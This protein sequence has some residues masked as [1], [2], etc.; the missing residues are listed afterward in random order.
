MIEST[1]IKMPL[2]VDDPLPGRI[3]YSSYVIRNMV[4]F[5][6]CL[7]FIPNIV[8]Y[9][10]GNTQLE[11]YL[12]SSL[13]LIGTLVAFYFLARFLIREFLVGSIIRLGNTLK[14]KHSRYS[15]KETITYDL[16][17][18]SSILFES[19]GVNSQYVIYIVEQSGE[20]HAII[21]KFTMVSV[22]K[23]IMEFI[24]K[25]SEVTELQVKK[26]GCS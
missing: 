16:G 7:V 14:H 24:S 1:E 23:E 21:E 20:R 13:T 3:L 22:E 12:P 25:L 19:L 6:L 18:M 2:I 11:S 4:L 9:I 15:R 17:K 5:I 26:V 10:E 8:L